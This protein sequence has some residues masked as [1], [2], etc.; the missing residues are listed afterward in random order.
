MA[1]AACMLRSAQVIHKQNSCLAVVSATSG[2]TNQLISLG[3]TAEKSTWAE[4][5]EMILNIRNRHHQIGDELKISV[6]SREKLSQLL[7]EMESLA[8]GIHLLRDCSTKAMDTMMSLGERLS[9]VLF[10]E[11]LGQVFLQHK[12]S[13]VAELFDARDVL[14][15]DDQFSKAR[16]LT[17]EIIKLCEKKMSRAKTGNT[18]LSP[19]ALSE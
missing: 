18:V 9:S 6:S 4:A 14:R 11:A 19:R 13:S 17:N 1:D 2:T 3:K 15:T 10:T 5:E 7:T 12:S 16:P 8:R